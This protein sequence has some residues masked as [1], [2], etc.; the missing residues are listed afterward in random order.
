[1][2]NTTQTI[3]NTIISVVIIIAWLYAYMFNVTMA[4]PFL[5]I[6]QIILTAIIALVYICK[7]GK[8][9]RLK[10]K[11]DELEKRIEELEKGR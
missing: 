3:C 10:T 4:I 1:M 6:L 11:T 8:Y 2:K 5:D 9:K 7:T